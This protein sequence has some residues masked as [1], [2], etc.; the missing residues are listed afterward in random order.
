MNNE[1]PGTITPYYIEMEN[2][3]ER[4]RELG[5]MDYPHKRTRYIPGGGAITEDVPEYL[6]EQALIKRWYELQKYERALD[7]SYCRNSLL[8]SLR[9][10]FVIKAEFD[11]KIAARIAI[12]VYRNSPIV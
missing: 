11:P 7:P 12:S 1:E 2:I 6:E 5:K 3:M 4:L 10:S 9:L 8:I